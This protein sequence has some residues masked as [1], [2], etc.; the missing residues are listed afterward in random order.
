MSMSDEIQEPF[1]YGRPGENPNAPG[2]RVTIPQHFPV[3]THSGQDIP[4]E[5]PLFRVLTRIADA[6]N[7]AYPIP[8]EKS[9]GK[10]NPGVADYHYEDPQTEELRNLRDSIKNTAGN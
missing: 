6:L 2:S 8:E 3:S 7:R 1:L 10:L 9:L 4:Y 5:H